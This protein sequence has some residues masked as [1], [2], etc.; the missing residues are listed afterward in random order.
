MSSES[1]KSN[2]FQSYIGGY[3][4][5]AEHSFGANLKTRTIRLAVVAI[6]SGLGFAL[7][8]G[9]V[10]AQNYPN[11]QITIVVPYPAGGGGDSASRI[12]AQKMGDILGRPVIV[13]NRAGAGGTIGTAT[14]ARA[15]AD[16]YTVL[17][18][19]P[20]L[21][22]TPALFKNPSFDAKRDFAPVVWI[23]SA[24]L[25]L[26]AHPSVP[27]RNVQELVALAKAKP[28]GI[29]FA[30][31][32]SGMSYLAMIALAQET[33]T[34]M[35]YVP[36][37][38]AGPALTDLIGGQIHVGF[39]ISNAIVEHSKAGKVRALAMTGLKRAAILPDVP[40]FKESGVDLPNL[41]AGIWWGL[42]VPAATPRDVIQ[43]L[44]GL[45]N[46]AL[47]DPDVRQRYASGGISVV[48]G[49]VEDF[50][51]LMEGQYDYWPR[52][53]KVAGVQPE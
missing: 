48:G 4:M 20:S 38:G 16:G 1:T 53:L 15:A 30:H 9:P 13:D 27:V 29:N 21:P 49:S 11:R 3:N 52:M 10:S 40:T 7:G 45:V 28:G 51:R 35:V 33:N 14:V 6:L 25:T 26:V 41:D 22:T 5:F 47:R 39:Q 43:R 42:M 8:A 46:E 50:A 36:Y 44:N 18:A 31:P 23:V 2:I 24:P 12:L 34:K 32:G 17:W 37:K 19:D